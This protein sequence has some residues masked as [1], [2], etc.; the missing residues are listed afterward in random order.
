MRLCSLDINQGIQDTF[1][2]II[3]LQMYSNKSCDGSSIDNLEESLTVKQEKIKDKVIKIF[4]NK[5]SEIIY[6]RYDISNNEDYLKLK[7]FCFAL[8]KL[9]D[10]KIRKIRLFAI[11]IAMKIFEFLFIDQEK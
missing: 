9:T 10:S 4:L 7:H 3:K 6:T 8:I 5:I 2:K 1:K 11:M